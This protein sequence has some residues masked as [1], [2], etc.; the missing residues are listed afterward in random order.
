M[1][2]EGPQERIIPTLLV[3]PEE[4]SGLENFNDLPKIPRLLQNQDQ[5]QDSLFWHLTVS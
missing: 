4:E 5:T 2:Q 3:P 1:E